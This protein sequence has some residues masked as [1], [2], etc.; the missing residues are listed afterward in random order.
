MSRL[1][2]ARI[3][4]IDTGK[5]VIVRKDY[6]LNARTR[7]FCAS[8]KNDKECNALLEVMCVKTGTCPF[9]KECGAD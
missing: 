9:F 7:R 1:P 3:R 8:W 4:K 2:V 5:G 6:A